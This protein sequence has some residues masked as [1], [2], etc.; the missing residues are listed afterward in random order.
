[1]S[2]PNDFNWKIYVMLNNDLKHMNKKD[3]ELHYIKFGIMENRQYK[4]RKKSLPND[5]N[6]KNY[7]ML[8]EDL[9]HMN[10]RQ[11]ENHYLHYGIK[12]HRQYMN[13]LNILIYLIYHNDE[14]YKKIEKY[15][16]YEYVILV[17]IET[18][19]YFESVIFEKLLQR[20][21]EW[22]SKDYV[23]ILTYSSERKLSMS[24][25]EI[26]QKTMYILNN[27]KYDLITFKYGGKKHG[28][29][30]YQGIQQIF[31][32]TLPSFGFSLPIDY[33]N[34]PVFYCNYWIVTPEWMDKY[35]TFALSYINKLEDVTDSHLQLLINSNS[36]HKSH[37]SSADL[38]R[39]IKFPYYPYHSIIMERLP[40]LFFWKNNF[41]QDTEIKTSF[42][43]FKH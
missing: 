12:E 37:L 26:Y 7:V 36:G 3:A 17:H 31:N 38:Q 11:A 15:Q 28:D 20:K 24:L 4:I 42:G 25:D 13:K 1:M 34:I 18:T 33:N 22:I 35:I 41:V 2:L 43:L 27:Y 6:W 30:Y 19:K 14:S 16:N 10:K 23:G 9:K 32:Y 21:S 40:S 5:F 29:S 39:L 8:H